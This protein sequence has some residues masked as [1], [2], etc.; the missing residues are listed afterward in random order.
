MVR[1][2]TKD[3][4]GYLIEDKLNESQI[5]EQKHYFGIKGSSSHVEFEFY[6]T[7]ALSITI[8]DTDIDG[9]KSTANVEVKKADLKKLLTFL[10]TDD[11]AKAALNEASNN[12][13]LVG[14]RI[15]TGGVSANGGKEELFQTLDGVFSCMTDGRLGSGYHTLYNFPK[16]EFL[17][18]LIYS[19][20][21]LKA[22]VSHGSPPKQLTDDQINRLQ[23]GAKAVLN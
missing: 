12:F 5:K 15:I 14:Q 22:V 17:A 1:S 3:R 2:G 20:G 19:G 21:V 10:Q 23:R 18:E 13:R 16:N 6:S 11:R 7:G 4:N 8:D 9:K